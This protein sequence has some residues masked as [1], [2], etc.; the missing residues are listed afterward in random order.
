MSGDQLIIQV[1]F[2]HDIRRALCSLFSQLTIMPAPITLVRA[3][4]LC[5][6]TLSSPDTYHQSLDAVLVIIFGIIVVA[7]DADILSTNIPDAVTL[8]FQS[9]GIAAGL[10]TVVTLLPL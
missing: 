10:L 2:G 4:L 1:T 7:L 6:S 8:D 9:L 5:E 3:I